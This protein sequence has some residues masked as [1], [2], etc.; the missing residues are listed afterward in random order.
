MILTRMLE[1]ELI[2]R[3]LSWENMKQG[4]PGARASTRPQTR[5]RQRDRCQGRLRVWMFEKADDMRATVPGK[6][7][8]SQLSQVLSDGECASK[9][10]KHMS[11]QIGVGTSGK[12]RQEVVEELSS[13][14]L[15]GGQVRSQ[16]RVS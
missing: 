10:S 14:Q 9:P 3:L 5:R 8:M 7:A 2:D 13:V 11:G 15:P 4:A 12:K 1:L 6:R 16:G